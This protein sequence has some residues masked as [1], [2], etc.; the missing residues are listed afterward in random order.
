MKEML[1]TITVLKVTMKRFDNFLQENMPIV[2]MMQKFFLNHDIPEFTDKRMNKEE[3]KAGR[4]L[5]KRVKKLNKD[6]VQWQD[7][8]LQVDIPTIRFRVKEATN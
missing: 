3:S 1:Q 7:K 8:R 4:T 6:D 2:M 5:I